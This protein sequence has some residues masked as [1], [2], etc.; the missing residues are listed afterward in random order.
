MPLIFP[1]VPLTFL[2]GTLTRLHKDLVRS[3]FFMTTNDESDHARPIVDLCSK[4]LIS[5]KIPVIVLCAP[6]QASCG[7]LVQNI[8]SRMVC[9]AN[10]QGSGKS[11]L[12]L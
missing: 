1:K 7:D 2:S 6:D 11:S 10:E 5:T 9:T 4:A 3:L 12:V 8:I